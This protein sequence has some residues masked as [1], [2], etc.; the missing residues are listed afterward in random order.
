MDRV[1]R[2]K[3]E[4]EPPFALG[5]LCP[6][7]KTVCLARSDKNQPCDKNLLLPQLP[8]RPPTKGVLSPTLSTSIY[9]PN[10]F[11]SPWWV[12]AWCKRNSKG[13]ANL[14]EWL[15]QNEPP[16][17]LGE[18]SGSSHLEAGVGMVVYCT[19]GAKRCHSSKWL[20][21]NFEQAAWVYIIGITWVLS[22]RVHIRTSF[23]SF[24]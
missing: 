4:T 19:R 9:C 5:D 16:K 22:G 8:R 11:L 20:S 15:W 14:N 3:P 10:C 21:N 24:S 6:R 7:W 12:L 2:T 13:A 23:L 18:D 17:E 1:A